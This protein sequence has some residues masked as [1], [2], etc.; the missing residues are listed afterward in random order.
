MPKRKIAEA[1]DNASADDEIVTLTEQPPADTSTAETASHPAAIVNQASSSQEG[2][3]PFGPN[4]KDH[5]LRE[6]GDEP[7]KSWV[8]KASIIVEPEAGVKFHFHYERHLAIITFDEKP[9]PELLAAVKP[10]LK[11]GGFHWDRE[12][13]G[14]T[15]RIAFA[16]REDDRRE[17][18]KTFYALANALREQKGLPTRSFGEALAF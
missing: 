1:Q 15:K 9:A 12:N 16:T 7:Q 8:N 2:L 5:S 14:W 11:D 18:K 4:G 3:P 13:E 10:I 17:A 6:P